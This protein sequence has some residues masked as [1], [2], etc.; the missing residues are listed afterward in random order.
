MDSMK[1]RF[2]DLLAR[3]N[4]LTAKLRMAI[5]FGASLVLAL[6]LIAYAY[7]GP[8][9]MGVLYSNLAPDDASRITQRL[10][11]MGVPYE[12]SQDG[13]SVLVPESRVAETRMTLAASGL[14]GHSG[15]G[16]EVFDQQRFGESEFSEQVKYHRALEGELSRTITQ[17]SGVDSARVHLVLPGRS[18]F[19]REQEHATASVVLHL[20]P[21][22]SLSPIQARGVVHLVSSAVRGLEGENVSIVDGD[23]RPIAGGER[24]ED[25]IAGDALAFRR[26]LEQDK[27]RAIQDLLDRTL[28]PGKAEVSVAADVSFTREEHTEEHYLPEESATRSFQTQTEG[29]ASA[30]AGT[31]GIPGAASNLPG[32]APPQGTAGSSSGGRHSETR[33]FEISKTTRHAIEPVGRLTR[34][35]VA[36]V[37]DGTWE[38]EG[39]ARAFSPLP[40]VELDRIQSIVAT[41][42][43]VDTERGDH[44]TVA[45]VPFASS[46]E[47]DPAAEADILAPYQ[48]YIPLVKLGG[49]VLGALFL[50]IFLLRLRKRMKKGRAEALVLAQQQQAKATAAAL[51]AGNS[52]IT[53]SELE[54]RLGA[55]MPPRAALATDVAKQDPDAIQLLAADLASQ[56]PARAARVIHGWLDAACPKPPQLWP[57]RRRPP[58]RPHPWP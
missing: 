41:A 7:A 49:A 15:V 44:V 3:Y 30:Q 54:A 29:S 31:Q 32:G 46:A 25:E 10:A 35:S 36:V 27:E 52:P 34:L 4:G 33:N 5:I 51:P 19:R 11:Q 21:G 39:D 24:G 16:F 23:G 2:A 53:V 55:G 58:P 45:C 28:G 13:T 38:G 40:Q 50:L 18:V 1:L 6:G 17:L 12:R 8:A 22:F 43:G 14:P 56:D 47:L 20:L 57:P 42:G 37:A 26:R 9:S 48:K